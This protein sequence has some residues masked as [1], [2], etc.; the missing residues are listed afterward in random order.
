MVFSM[1]GYG[2]ADNNGDEQFQ[3]TVEIRSVNHRYLDVSVRM[4]RELYQLEEKV[5]QR[6]QQALGRGRIEVAISFRQEDDSGISIILDR[7]LL[8]AYYD[9]L[10]E[11]A[12]VCSL[13]EKPN[14]KLL[15]AF[16]DV[17]RVEKNKLDI[18]SIW[19]KLQA[20]IDK[21][22]AELLVQRRDEGERLAEDIK[23]RLQTIEEKAG[24]IKK[25][26]PF[27]VEDYRNK[28]SE[29]IKEYLGDFEAD[30]ARLLTEIA[31]FTDKSNVTEELVRLSSHLAGFREALQE[32]G[33]VGRKLD[34]LTQE[35]FREVNTIGSKANDYEAAKLVVEI[36]AEL[37]KIREQ[38]Q[39]IE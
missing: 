31:I 16:P 20:V 8:V 24:L 4:P 11:I 27:I 35:L 12:T 36:K 33:P 28:I 13:D 39:N 38:V 26:A 15:A 34:F 17:L 10:Q 3:F 18:E 2:R 25:R 23:V 14:L 6:I 19:E 7:N 29:R 9:A 32:E 30:P 37:E 21:A 5:R 22:I 1:T